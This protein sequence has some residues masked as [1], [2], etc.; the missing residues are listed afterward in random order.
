MINEYDL[1]YVIKKDC[2]MS[3]L[4]KPIRNKIVALELSTIQKHSNS[5]KHYAMASA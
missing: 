4:F 2:G 3:W 5:I 1:K